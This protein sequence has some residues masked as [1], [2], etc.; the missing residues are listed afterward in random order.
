MANSVCGVYKIT[1]TA[2]GKYYV[3]SSKNIKQRWVRHQ[4]E[5]NA[6]VH[7]NKYLQNA[8][9]KYGAKNFQFEIIEECLVDHQFEREQ[10]YLNTLNPFGDK[11]YNIIR[12]ISKEY[13]SD[14]CI[15]KICSRCTREYHTFSHLSKYCD[16]CKEEIAKENFENFQTERY[17][18]QGSSMCFNAMYD[19]YDD[20][21][22]FWE[23]NN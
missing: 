7:G 14:N 15:V 17:W 21:E 3:G 12:Q 22:D 16:E 6:G 13:M 4:N 10:F 20:M 23:S 8:W 18:M 9:N 1:N 5:L 2:N 19:G 11:G